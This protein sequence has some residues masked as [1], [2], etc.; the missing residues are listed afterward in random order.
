[1]NKKIY[2]YK[3]KSKRTKITINNYPIKTGWKV[4]D[5]QT[6]LFRYI[7]IVSLQD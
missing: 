2:E 4:T 5:R 6:D 1:M 7:E 3:R